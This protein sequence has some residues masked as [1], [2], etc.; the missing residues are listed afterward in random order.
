MTATVPSP[1]P[2]AGRAGAAT[3]RRLEQASG[4]LATSAVARMDEE[5][6]WF[7]AMPAEQRSWVGLVAHAGIAAFLDW[8]RVP[9]GEVPGVSGEVFGAAPRELTR[10]ITLRQTVELVRVTID[11][12]ETQVDLLAAPGEERLLREGLL[13]Y[14]REIAFAAADV[15]AQA[16]EERGAWDARLEALVVDALLRGETDDALRSRAAALGWGTPRSVCVLVGTPADAPPDAVLHAL[17][18]SARDEGLDALAAVHGE[19]LV[20]VLGNADDP[21]ASA[22]RLL[23]A[24]GTGP[25]VL[26]PT[27]AD[28][29]AAAHSAAVALAGLRAVAGRPQAARPVLADDLLPERA[30]GGDTEAQRLLV[31]EVYRRLLTGGRPLLDTVATY[32][33]SAGSLEA[34]ARSLFVHANTVRYRLRK[35]AELTGYA[36]T[37]PR[38]AFVL[39]V[40]LVLGRLRGAEPLPTLDL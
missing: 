21:A 19:R 35:A 22:G 39:Q 23:E 17:Q 9:E 18:R 8:L 10:A 2:G 36:A 28:L 16:A 38:E 27:V 37:D 14:S 32:V 31:E 4:A 3:L 13:R 30:L 34:T 6:L 7:R 40:A 5:L 26:G 29:S 25:V 12:V 11:V 1:R 15:Y 33:E 20:V 24:F